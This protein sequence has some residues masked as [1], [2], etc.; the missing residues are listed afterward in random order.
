M[1]VQQPPAPATP[2][3]TPMPPAAKKGGCAGCSMGCLGC[4]GVVLLVIALL[5]GGGYF[6]LVAQAQAGVASPAALLVATTPV[7]VGHND[8]GYKPGISGQSLDAGS[9][10]LTGCT[11]H[12]TI[13]CTDDI[14]M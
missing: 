4:I 2:A 9:S 3:S 7:D 14:L 5:V 1:A 13:Q 6:F 8:G 12:Y 11:G 10:V